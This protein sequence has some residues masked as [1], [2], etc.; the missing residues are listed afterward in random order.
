V[1]LYTSHCDSCGSDH[2]YVRTIANRNDTPLCCDKQTAKV[3][4]L[5]M[6]GALAFTGHKGFVASATADSKWIESGSDLKRY[7]NE[8][9]FVTEGEGRE[10]AVDAK[11]N[12]EID[13]DK[14][15]DQ[16]IDKARTIHRK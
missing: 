5:P 15:L 16:A 8:N 2:S 1:P 12:Q 7:M 11:R 10:R 9:N 3:L 13:F 4:D 14:K 6:I